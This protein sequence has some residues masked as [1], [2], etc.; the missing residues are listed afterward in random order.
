[1]PFTIV[2]IEIHYM[3]FFF[4]LW[5]CGY[6]DIQQIR[7]KKIPLWRYRCRVPYTLKKFLE[8]LNLFFILEF[9]EI[10]RVLFYKIE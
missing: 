10:G 4:L 8:T 6:K 7:Y 9:P 3:Q 2:K 1:M 5:G